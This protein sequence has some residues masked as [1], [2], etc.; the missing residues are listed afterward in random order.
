[1]RGHASRS[2]AMPTGRR[3]DDDKPTQ[4]GPRKQQ[5]IDAQDDLGNAPP[6]PD[7]Y[8]TD[9]SSDRNRNAAL[10]DSTGN[11]R[12]SAEAAGFDVDENATEDVQRAERKNRGSRQSRDPKRR[13]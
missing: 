5:H 1:M 8:L 11:A 3:P 9:L 7:D 10:G 2:P 6:S 4:A 13:F 12:E